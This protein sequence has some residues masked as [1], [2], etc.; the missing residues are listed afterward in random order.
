MRWDALFADL[1]AQLGAELAAEAGAEVAER[2]RAEHGA[3]LLADRVRA[4]AGGV[5]RL[6]LRDG[7]S[8]EGRCTDVGSQ[9]VS[10]EDGPAQLLVPWDAVTTV[11]GLGRAAAQ[12]AGVAVRR[13]SLRHALRALSRGRTPVVLGLEG[14]RLVGT[15]DRV[16]ADHLD[17][18]EH[19]AGEARRACEVRG[20]RTVR[21]AALLW[22]RSG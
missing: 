8:L 4:H 10:L 20:V 19:P 12:P 17:L 2:T 6:G 22:V 16:G 1:E 15:V 3:L 18:A 9:W 21:T 7:S 5:L 11:A 13:L 14:G